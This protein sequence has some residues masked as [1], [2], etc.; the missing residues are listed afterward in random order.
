VAAHCDN[1][2]IDEDFDDVQ[3]NFQEDLTDTDSVPFFDLKI[4]LLK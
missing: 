1:K 2:Y 3:D 4:I